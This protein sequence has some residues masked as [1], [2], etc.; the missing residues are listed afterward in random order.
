MTSN[1]VIDQQKLVIDGNDNPSSY[2]DQTNL[3]IIYL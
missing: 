1:T 2:Q 3:G